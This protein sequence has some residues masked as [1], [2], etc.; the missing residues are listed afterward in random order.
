MRSILFYIPHELGGVPLFGFGLLLA[1]LVA[2]FFVWGSYC[3]ASGKKELLW[4]PLP[5]FGIAGL[6][7]VFLL[8][9]VESKFGDG[10][11]IGL[12]IRGYGIL[13]LSGLL[14]G[15]GISIRR[16]RQLGLDADTIMGLGFWMMVTGVAGARA[17]YVVQK[18]DEFQSI[19]QIFQVTEGGL[20][21]YG[22]VIGG[23]FACAWYCYRKG[24][25]LSATGD[26]VAPGFLIGLSFGRIGCLLHGCCF[27]GVCT[28][29]LP[30]IRF[31]HGSIPFQSQIVDGTLL[32]LKTEK[33]SIPGKIISVQADSPA[34]REGVL[35]GQRLESINLMPVEKSSDENPATPSDIYAEITVEGSRIAFLPAALGPASLPTQPSQIYSSINAL[36]LCV[37]VWCLQ[38]V[39][40]R[41]GETLCFAVSTYAASRFVLE[42]VRSDEVGQLGTSFTISQLVSLGMIVLVLSLWA[43]LRTRPAGRSWDWLAG[44]AS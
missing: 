2:A 43:W 39:P 33:G 5:M 44:Q 35:V 25:K 14:A 21:I 18:W 1:L 12:P 30:S 26:L 34:D 23:L 8:P 7:V 6:V 3:L 24:L 22:G 9:A 15:I 31:P 42:W 28:A 4:D 36:L 10:T 20:V 32:G 37:L 40:L 13:V 27:G 16:G 17:F 38:P 11:P 29:D 19:G 41:D